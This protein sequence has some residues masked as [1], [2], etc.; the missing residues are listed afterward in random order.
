[1]LRIKV[2]QLISHS[3][4]LTV[5][6][7]VHNEDLKPRRKPGSETEGQSWRF[8]LNFISWTNYFLKI[9]TAT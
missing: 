6:V 7:V 2:H 1:M 4:L 9:F 8:Q 3:F 5:V